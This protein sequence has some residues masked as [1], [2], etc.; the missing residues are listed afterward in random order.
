VTKFMER[1]REELVRR[2]YAASTI[3]SYLRIVEDFH[4]Y[5]GKRLDHLGPDDLRRYHAQLL[6][7]RKLA[8]RTV[9]QHVAA[10]RFLYCKTLKRRDMKEDLPYPR[11]YRRQLPVI[12]S[13][14]EVAR[15][16]DSARNLYHRAMLM[17]LYSCGLRR[18]EVCRLKVSDI[19]SQ[20]MMLRITHGK[21]GVDR[22]VPLSPRLLET[23]REYWRWL[24]PKTYLFPGTENGWRTDKPITAKMVWAAVN[25]AAKRA[26]ITKHVSPHLLRHSYAT[27]QLEAGMDLKTLQVLLGHEDL[28][29]TSRYLHLSQKHLQAVSTPL[30]RIGMKPATQ[31]PRSR[32]LRKPE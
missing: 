32:R 5:A 1:M 29:T 20:R 19:D 22:D 12:L 18:I 6:E 23:L 31:V 7:E 13:P 2:N 25:L 14:D 10:V 28:A 11:N 4:Q 16:I 27:H 24:R 9:V 30:D 26:G 21:G 17:T 3:S 8:V 15:V